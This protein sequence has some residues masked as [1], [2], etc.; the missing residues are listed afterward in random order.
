MK[1]GRVDA[2][3]EASNTIRLI[4]EELDASKFE[5]VIGWTKPSNTEGKINFLA[6][7]PFNFA[8]TELR[9]AF[10]GALVKLMADGT[11]D[12]ITAKYGFSTADRP[13][14]NDPTLAEE[15]AA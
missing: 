13:G 14:A 7:F 6:A 4:F 3:V 15:C 11:V 10:D 2:I 9:D 1:V 8:A 12:K 5:R